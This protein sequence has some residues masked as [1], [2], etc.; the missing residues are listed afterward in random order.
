M[1]TRTMLSI[2]GTLTG[3]V[4]SSSASMT[5][6]GART[7]QERDD[8]RRGH[9]YA[10]ARACI[11]QQGS[12]LRRRRA[13]DGVAARARTGELCVQQRREYISS[14]SC[15]CLLRAPIFV[16]HPPRPRPAQPSSYIARM[17]QIAHVALVPQN[18]VSTP[19]LM[20]LCC[21]PLTTR[22]RWGSLYPRTWRPHDVRSARGSV[23]CRNA[24]RCR[25]TA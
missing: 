16:V 21:A 19:Y 20:H 22:G 18:A 9:L 2:N 1:Y 3:R 5:R 8:E 7:T 15:V 25:R 23:V 6:A 12:G 17:W 24:A 10:H 4:K 13:R 14:H 11:Q